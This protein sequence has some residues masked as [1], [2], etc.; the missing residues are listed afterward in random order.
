[1][2]N[3][4]EFGSNLEDLFPNL[5]DGPEMPALELFG[6][7]GG[8]ATF[9]Q[10]PSPFTETHLVTLFTLHKC[11]SCHSIQHTGGNYAIR[12]LHHSRNS[13]IEYQSILPD[14]YEFFD[15]LPKAFK[16]YEQSIPF[17][18]ACA[19]AKGFLGL[20]VEDI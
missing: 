1:M 20:N 14:L 10:S 5:D 6:D 7:F 13:C 15:H 4:D 9:R 8:G 12:R 2:S 3:H 11:E 18:P 17:C 19:E 16:Y